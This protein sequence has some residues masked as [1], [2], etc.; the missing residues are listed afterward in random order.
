MDIL[1]SYI[2]GYM[3]VGLFF[4]VVLRSGSKPMQIKEY[5]IY[6]IFWGVILV[7]FTTTYIV[8]FILDFLDRKL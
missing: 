1:L 2:I 3:F 6:I 4:C 5:I 7:A 8:A